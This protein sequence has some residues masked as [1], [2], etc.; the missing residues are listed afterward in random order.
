MCLRI[1]SSGGFFFWERY[2]IF[3][4]RKTQGDLLQAERLLVSWKGLFIELSAWVKSLSQT[5]LMG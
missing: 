5:L 1:G 4:L 3:G 2:Q